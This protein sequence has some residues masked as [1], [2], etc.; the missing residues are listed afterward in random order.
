MEAEH[1]IWCD[2]DPI[3][4]HDTQQHGA[5]RR[6]G[7]IDGDLFACVPQR[8]KTR[9]VSADIAAVVVGDAEDWRGCGWRQQQEHGDKDSRQRS[10]IKTSPPQRED[11][12]K[13]TEH[14][15][16]RIKDWRE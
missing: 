1:R 5:G 7:S 3:V 10:Q 16:Q 8:D 6:T 14:S 4:R 9:I 12:K 15:D 2:A 13:R 11:D